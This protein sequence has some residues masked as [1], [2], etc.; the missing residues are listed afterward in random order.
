MQCPSGQQPLAIDLL[1]GQA[2]KPL[3]SDL[4]FVEAVSTYPGVPYVRGAMKPNI[5][6]R[7]ILNSTK[8]TGPL[9]PM[10]EYCDGRSL[11]FG[12]GTEIG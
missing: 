5:K 9:I 4:V 10:S 12:P 6:N 2:V 3:V 8:K 7:M 1:S 11:V